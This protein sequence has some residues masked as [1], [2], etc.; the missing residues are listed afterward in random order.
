MVRHLGGPLDEAGIYRWLAKNFVL[1]EQ[2]LEDVGRERRRLT[3][4]S[5]DVIFGQA[6][7]ELLA[8]LRDRAEISS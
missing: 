5:I 7:Y 2:A 8:P 4:M 3:L 6:D 1:L